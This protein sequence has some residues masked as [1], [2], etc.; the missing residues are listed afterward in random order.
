M[1]ENPE[2]FPQ[3]RSFGRRRAA[4]AA[5]VLLALAGVT[6]LVLAATREESRLY[7]DESPWNRPIDDERPDPRSGR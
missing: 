6:A 1:P 4:L 5:L 2:R 3:R 7:S